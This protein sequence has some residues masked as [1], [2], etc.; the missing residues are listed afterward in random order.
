MMAFV[1]E[2]ANSKN[3][4][5]QSILS[6]FTT[7]ALV[8]I[9]LMH[10]SWAGN[11]PAS[12]DKITEILWPIPFLVLGAVF[13]YKSANDDSLLFWKILSVAEA[14]ICIFTALWLLAMYEFSSFS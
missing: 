12:G 2:M 14:L 1:K 4:K 8:T 11:K 10:D 5:V 13:A 7:L 9:S 6:L 3:Y